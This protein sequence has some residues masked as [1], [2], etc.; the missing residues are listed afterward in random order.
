MREHPCQ[1]HPDIAGFTSR[2]LRRPRP[3]RGRGERGRAA[4]PADPDAS[5]RHGS[6]RR[7][8]VVGRRGG[9]V[10]R[11][12]V[13]RRRGVVRRRGVRRRR[14][15]RGFPP[16]GE[17]N[18][19]PRPHCGAPP[20]PTPVT[21]ATFSAPAEWA[22]QERGRR[23]PGC[24]TDRPAAVGVGTA[25]GV[26]TAT[27]GGRGGRGGRASRSRAGISRYDTGGPD[28]GSSVK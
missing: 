10:G 20:R 2:A 11:R 8:G 3:R 6:F 25:A 17:R 22:S 12:G 18:P 16:A 14:E 9:V 26:G 28:S 4:P 24:R 23:A 13:C 5:R 21:R 27:E 1:P 15:V 19:R 7:R